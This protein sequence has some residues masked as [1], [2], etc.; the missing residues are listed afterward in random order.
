M[1]KR[2]LRLLA[3]FAAGSVVLSA[4]GKPVKLLISN[5]MKSVMEELAPQFEK[6][7]GAPLAIQYS[8]TFGL[9]KKIEAGEVFDATVI[10][11]EGV[12]ALAKQGKLAEG[13]SAYLGRSPLGIGIRTGARK[14]DIRTVAAF[15]Q[16]LL[17]AKS[18][19]YPQD[20]ATRGFIDDMF[21]KLGIAAQVK[22]KIILAPSSGESTENVA[23]GKAEFV[24]TLFSEIV[25]VKGIEV[26]GPLP[27][28]YATYVNF[29]A[30]ASSG[31]QNMDAAKKFV[32]FMSGPKTAPL[33]KAKGLEVHP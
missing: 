23:T 31:A 33:L 28:K 11:S 29:T 9:R 7:I 21:E 19:T 24:I 13:S 16:T 12:T 32:A 3:T 30:A 22:P 18:I 25:P 20:G 17:D 10:T 5:G 27:G 26:L 8:S 2:S 4:Q 14:P 6:A 15:K 1:M